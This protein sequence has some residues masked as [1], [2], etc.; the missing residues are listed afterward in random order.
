MY[1]V[2]VIIVLCLCNTDDR[3]YYAVF[4]MWFNMFLV[5]FAEFCNGDILLMAV[6]ARPDSDNFPPFVF[7]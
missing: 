6:P 2:D 3:P 4:V 1:V 7:E 5:L